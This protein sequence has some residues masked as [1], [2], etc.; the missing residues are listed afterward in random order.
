LKIV[1]IN[2]F[3][4]VIGFFI[5][6]S[7][8]AQIE[9]TSN[10]EKAPPDPL[11]FNKVVFKGLN[12]YYD[13]S[14]NEVYSG[15]STSNPNYSGISYKC[16]KDMSSMRKRDMSKCEN[17]LEKYAIY[18]CEPDKQTNKIYVSIKKVNKCNDLQVTVLTEREVQNSI[19][20]FDIINGKIS[21]TTKCTILRGGTT[22]LPRIKIFFG[23]YLDYK[24]NLFILD[25]K[26]NK[27]EE[28]F[29]KLMSY[30]SSDEFR[31]KQT[32]ALHNIYNET[33]AHMNSRLGFPSYPK[34]VDYSD[35]QSIYQ[36][37]E[38]LLKHLGITSAKSIEDSSNR[39]S[40]LRYFQTV[41]SYISR[42]KDLWYIESETGSK[43]KKSK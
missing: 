2:I 3:L 13:S 16:K 38:N 29:E 33:Y 4:A 43:S 40:Y 11:E 35:S 34:E 7:V 41:C 12:F 28:S 17:G 21:A 42:K 32:I 24:A 19:E 27:S 10:V 9:N 26:E 18:S 25:I 20:S 5:T 39:I 14:S 37:N 15:M 22:T 31:K 23:S 6:T 36:I 1:K 8:I 30:F